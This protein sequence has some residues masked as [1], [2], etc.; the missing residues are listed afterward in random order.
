MKRSTFLCAFALALTGCAS[1]I[2]SNT[3][4]ATLEPQAS[5]ALLPL[6]NNT[7]T[8]QA[9]LSAESL[10][11]HMLR[12]RGIAGLKVYPATLSRDSLFEASERKV[13]EEAAAWARSQGVRYAISGSV[14]EWRYKVG[15]DGEPVVGITLKI[16]D[17]SSGQTVWSSAA[18]RSG[19]SRQALSGVAQSVMSEALASL[20]LA[21]D[22][23]RK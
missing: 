17:L 9:A 20:P 16:T 15:L 10:L 11:E 23:G 4:S 21:A 13:S 3:G 22:A 5:W 6:A 12:K 18:A 2:E 14:E 1:S 19:W 7:D 8:P